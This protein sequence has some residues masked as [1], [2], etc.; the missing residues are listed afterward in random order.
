MEGLYFLGIVVSAI[1]VITLVGEYV[2]KKRAAPKIEEEYKPDVPDIPD[3]VPEAEEGTFRITTV[4]MKIVVQRYKRITGLGA[5][6]SAKGDPTH[7][8]ETQYDDIGILAG[9]TRVY[10]E[11]DHEIDAENKIMS[12]LAE[13]K[14]KIQTRVEE[15]KR[16]EEFARAHP[17]REIPPYK[18][19]S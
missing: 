19:V 3:F 17:T 16:R 15:L 18:Y 10:W 6:L 11:F 12:A 7:H 5:F 14:R 8:W 13:E 1:L 2:S 4:G 9:R